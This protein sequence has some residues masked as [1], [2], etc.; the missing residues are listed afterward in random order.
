[1]LPWPEYRAT[2]GYGQSGLVRTTWLFTT[3]LAMIDWTA[4]DLRDRFRLR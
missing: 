2:F 1:M 3:R 4:I